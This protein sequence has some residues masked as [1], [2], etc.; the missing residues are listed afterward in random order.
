MTDMTKP[1][2]YHCRDARSFRVLWMLEELGTDYR[3]E[4]LPFPPRVRAPDFLRLNPLGTIPLFIEG[5]VRMTESSAIC[6]YL[7]TTCGDGSLAVAP[8]DDRYAAYL[9]AL[10]FGEA[11]LTYPQTVVLRYAMLEPEDRRQPQVAEDYRR[12]YLARL[13]GLEAMLERGGGHVAGP[14]F[15]AADISVGYALMLAQM[16]RLE[17]EGLFRVPAYWKQLQARPAFERA[18]VA[19]QEVAAA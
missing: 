9:E 6:H 16:L 13:T 3:L 10:S 8:G 2:L 18:K 12:W 1:I 14:A 7:A 11:T 5:A 17:A 15:T 19:Q 4:S